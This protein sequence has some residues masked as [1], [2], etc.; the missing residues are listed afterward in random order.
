LGIVKGVV[1]K[2]KGPKSPKEFL[3]SLFLS[4]AK[5][6]NN[7][8]FLEME[9]CDSLRRRRRRREAPFKRFLI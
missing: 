8:C 1:I 5:N 7:F 6:H 4:L 3:L 9:S 2:K